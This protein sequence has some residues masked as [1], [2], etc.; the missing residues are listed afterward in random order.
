MSPVVDPPYDCQ[1]CGA[2][3]GFL[4]DWPVVG[5]TDHGPDGPPADMVEDGHM[6]WVKDRCVAL[7]GAIGECVS[8]TI[9]VR[10]PST[11]RGCEPGSVSCH[12]ARRFHNLP[13]KG[14]VS[15]MEGLFEFSEP[16]P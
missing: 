16:G 13:V 7:E 6:R 15:T 12:E 1:A 4:A 3:C 5:P 14:E 2:C 11:C 8:C 10:R 9:Y